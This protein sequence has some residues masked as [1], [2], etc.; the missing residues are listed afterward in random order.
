MSTIMDD[1]RFSLRWFSRNPGFALIAVAAL[2]IGIG[3]NTSIFSVVNGVLLQPLPY[4]QPERLVMIYAST[5]SSR[6]AW[7]RYSDFLDWRRENQSFT[8]IAAVGGNWAFNLSG[9]DRPE[10]VRG[11]YVSA[12]L[13]RLL[14][15]DPR[16][17]R[18]FATNRL[19]AG[20]EPLSSHHELRSLPHARRRRP[21]LTSRL[22]R[23]G[24]GEAHAGLTQRA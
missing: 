11:E 8:D 4:S 17:W 6:E 2:A 19:V 13:F 5:P 10:H 12:N 7:V 1:L 20:S 14:G 24:F 9:S 18:R 16:R 21:A 15:V 23:D 3:A 22:G